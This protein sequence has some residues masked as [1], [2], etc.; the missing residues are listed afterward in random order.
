M[1]RRPVWGAVRVEYGEGG[2]AWAR[3]LVREDGVRRDVR[4]RFKGESM[5]SCRREA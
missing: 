5:E 4:D 2:G 1:E 3:E